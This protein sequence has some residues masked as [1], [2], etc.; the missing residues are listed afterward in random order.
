MIFVWFPVNTSKDWTIAA[1]W[2]GGS[3]N[4]FF[5]VRIVFIR[6]E[7][8]VMSIKVR[9][10]RLNKMSRTNYNWIDNRHDLCMCNSSLQHAMCIYALPQMIYS[11]LLAFSAIDFDFGFLTKE[12]DSSGQL[13]TFSGFIIISTHS[14]MNN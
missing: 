13:Y 9:W 10:K 3:R 12:A 2:I 1:W 14:V 7:F 4:L 8:V 11:V 5:V 6:D